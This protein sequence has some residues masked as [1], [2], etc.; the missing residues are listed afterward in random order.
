MF[1]VFTSE[2]DGK[3]YFRLKAANGETILSSQAYADRAGCVKGIESVRANAGDR[4]RF[5]S[6]TSK[7]GKHYFVLKAANAEVIGTSQMYVSDGGVK[8]GIESVGKNA[9]SAEIQDAG[10]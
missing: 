5:E 6:L 2:K 1:E 3:H 10:E 9:P 7:S 4:S 8:T